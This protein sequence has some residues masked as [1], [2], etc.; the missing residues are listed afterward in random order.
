[1]AEDNN[2]TQQVS[3]STTQEAQKVRN[4]NQQKMR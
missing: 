3:E 4:T 1:M 2:N